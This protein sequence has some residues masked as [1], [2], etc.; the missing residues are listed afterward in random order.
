MQ[1]DFIE[2]INEFGES[3]I[4]LYDF[5]QAQSN[6]FRDMIQ[7][8]I[9]EKGMKV[10]LGNIDFIE[11]RNCNLIMGIG[12]SDEGIISADNRTFFCI[13]RL[14]SYVTMI[15][16]LKPF[17]EKETKAHQYLYEV[18]TPIDLLFAP[19]GSWE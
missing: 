9:I 14:E 16:L 3:L 13:L 8:D 18:D 2:N 19:A 1:L 6:L 10:N 4:R 11:A 5:D 15:E 12:L 7:Y 17:C